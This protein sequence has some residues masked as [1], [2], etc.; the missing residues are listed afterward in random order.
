MPKR[1]TN[2]IGCD[3]QRCIGFMFDD[4]CPY[5][6]L[7]ACDVYKAA[8]EEQADGDCQHLNRV[9]GNQNDYC[10]DCGYFPLPH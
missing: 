1:K 3:N 9:R 6:R 10:S 8:Q 4:N 7:D 2:N 5:R